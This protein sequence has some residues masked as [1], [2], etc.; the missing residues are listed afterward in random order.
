M[1]HYYSVDVTLNSICT[2]LCLTNI[3]RIWTI[4]HLRRSCIIAY[5]RELTSCYNGFVYRCFLLLFL[6]RLVLYVLFVILD[7]SWRV[8]FVNL[9]KTHLWNPN[10]IKYSSIGEIQNQ[11]WVFNLLILTIPEKDYWNKRVL[12]TNVKICVLVFCIF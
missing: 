11:Q 2:L 6:R 7:E 3:L 1:C 5:Q 10:Q 8:L 4:F 9:F 12:R